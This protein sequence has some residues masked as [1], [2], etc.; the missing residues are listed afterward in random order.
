MEL[1]ELKELYLQGNSLAELGR[2]YGIQPTTIKKYLINAGVQ[3]RSRS[4]QNSLSN[5]KRKKRVKDNYFSVIDN[6]NKAWLLGF[7]MADGSIRKDR[8]EIRIN[9]S[10]ID[11]EIL[12]KIR[13]ELEIEREIASEITNQGYAISY[14]SWSSE[15]QKIDLAKY[16][17]VPNKTYLPLHLP[18]F[19]DDSYKLAFILGFYDGDGSFSVN[20]KYCR[21]R[22][23]SHR[24]EI[25]EDIAKFFESKYGAT[26]SLSQDNRQLYELS[27][28][29]QF[30]VPVLKDMYSLNSIRLDRKYQK[31]LEY[32]NQET[33][34]SRLR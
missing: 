10:S 34:I 21:L 19:N 3:I 1:Q 17:V 4:E 11:I 14:L 25:L 9:L 23:V 22:L 12:E 13:N 32:I 27:I 15:Q 2:K 18:N 31:Y 24:S 30:A 28:S 5:K 33:T 6:V 8:N 16:G 7:L 29:T 26:Y 20:D